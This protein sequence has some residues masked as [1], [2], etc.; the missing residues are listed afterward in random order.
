MV[1]IMMN[2]SFFCF[3]LPNLQIIKLLFRSRIHYHCVLAKRE[4]DF[5]NR[6]TGRSERRAGRRERVNI[7]LLVIQDFF[8]LAR[9]LLGAKEAVSLLVNLL[10]L[11]DGELTGAAVDEEEKTTDNGED[12]EEVVLG[13]VLLGVV[14]V[15]LQ[16]SSQ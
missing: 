1:M 13:K 4:I 8:V 5:L 12:L 16:P 7:S 10:L 9:T 11:V 15:E 3:I 2:I 6:H 14:L